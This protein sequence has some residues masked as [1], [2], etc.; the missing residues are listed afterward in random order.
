MAYNKTNWVDGVTPLSARN[1]NKIENQLNALET[2]KETKTNVSAIASKV[3][4]VEN[5]KADK[6][7]LINHAKQRA[8]HNEWGHIRLADLVT[9]PPNNIKSSSILSGKNSIMLRWVDPDDSYL[10]DVKVAQWS[11]TI[12]RKKIGS[13]PTSPTDGELVVDSKVKNRYSVNG[14][15]DSG[16]SKGITYYY[17]LFPYNEKGI[18]NTNNVKTNKLSGAPLTY[19]TYTQVFTTSGT[20]T[21]P[22]GVKELDVFLVGGGGGG[23]RGSS[24]SLSG[25]GGG[26]GYTKVYK[27]ATTG[28]R[29][30]NA[31][32][33]TPGDVCTIVVGSGGSGAARVDGTGI[34]RGETGGA[35]SITIKGK[36]YQ[37]LG[38]SGGSGEG[39]A[40]GSG[41]GGGTRSRDYGAG[42]GGSNGENGTSTL[43]RNGGSGQ[44]H[45][46]REWGET[47]G[48]LYAG[49]GGG[50]G[51]NSSGGNGGAG[52]GGNGRNST[53]EATNGTNSLGGGGGGSYS[54]TTPGNGG[55]GKVIIRW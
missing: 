14:F 7:A 32:S 51:Y 33:V 10:Q 3:I 29:T 50:G 55:S 19:N 36:V 34:K 40:G 11:G 4:N 2:N 45:S 42:L 52:G 9:I 35:S 26:G 47:S 21:I 24:V 28:Y 25:G 8:G 17:R 6:T 20:Y 38:G 22:P 54:N 43:H 30:G 16:L 1:M 5:K 23:A 15:V 41:G 39:G 12:V 31:I 27:R 53:R 13:Y 18:F 48:R 44:G 37:A 49:G 46:T